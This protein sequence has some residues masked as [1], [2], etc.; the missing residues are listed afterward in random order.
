MP[1][2]ALGRL[3]ARRALWFVATWAVLVPLGFAAAA[4]ALGGEGL[5][6]RLEAGDAP[7]VNSESRT[8]FRLLERS[9][10]A[11]PSVQLLL[12]K[13]NPESGQLRGAAAS[14]ARSAVEVPEVLAVI[15][16]GLPEPAPGAAAATVSADGR[17]VLFTVQLRT[18]L[19]EEREQAA[20]DR[21][22]ALLEDVPHQ[23]AGSVG[24]VGG[25]SALV[26]EI[27]GQVEEDVQTGETVALPVSLLLMV[28]VFGGF[29]AAGLPIV[30]AIASIAGA[31]ASLLGFSYLLNLDSTVVSVVSV[32]GLGLCIDYGLLLVS[33]YREELRSGAGT[34]ADTSVPFT[35]SAEDLEQALVRT[36][37][38]AGR[39][40]LFSAVTVA[41][42]LG[43]LLLFDATI[44]RGVGA[45]GVSVVLVALVVALTLVPALIALGGARLVR[46]GL[47]R[48]VPGVGALAQRLGD[49]APAEGAFSR[50]ARRVQRRPW[51]VVVGVLAVLGLTAVPAL[52]LR[53]ISSGAAL[54]PT[55]S[56]QRQLFEAV[57]ERFPAL[58]QP[59]LQIVTQ[60][61]AAALESW[62]PQVA[63]LPGV[64]S[65][66]PVQERG[67][68]AERVA[69]L[70]VHAD[71][72]ADGDV[73]RGLVA[74]L[75]ETRPDDALLVTGRSA[76]VED[77]V[78]G[79]TN[80]APLAAGVV[81]LATFV[82]LFLM[83]GSLLV[84]LK[85]LVMNVVSL[86][87]SVG[88]LVWVFQNG[89]LESL[90]RFSST[91]GIETA[92]P[93]LV[94]AFGFGLAMD[95][96]VFLLSR[97]KEFRDAGA[98]NDEAVVRGLQRS[99]RIITS[100]AL[101][102]VLVFSGFVLGQLLI[103][104]QTGV[105]IAVAVAVD[106]TLIRML[107]VPATMTLLGEWNWWAPGP[108]RRL[109]EKFGLAESSEVELRPGPST[110]SAA[111]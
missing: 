14:L 83:T 15:G 62:A 29:L 96:E 47:A 73:A 37:A 63:A 101:I 50:L 41:I 27:N 9:A 69:V 88:V 48:R 46:P 21:V 17:A 53:L 106:A 10:P 1:L 23:V 76:L 22:T 25:Y 55:S 105:A 58:R 16:P 85:A 104:K 109:H 82:L 91:G 108:L 18:G 32:L 95:Y 78:Q 39:T 45:A 44:L 87:A 35:P 111:T 60:G 54:L 80:R 92:I 81:V 12:D 64:A 3:I 84:P 36:M 8:G 20:L 59:P 7:Q 102:V 71:G 2:P 110:A 38:T 89:N 67:E 68:G 31:L 51:W 6:A 24:T 86:G 26:D 43:G 97:I 74:T 13:V 33:R 11:G 56:E 4:G 42:S 90:L 72:G 65:V 77:F 98:S 5:F 99:G 100:A 61:P 79:L 34:M 28:L 70:A 93:A 107:L 19:E 30:G 52:H 40:V 75:R 57:E 66:D 103:I 94:L 49:V